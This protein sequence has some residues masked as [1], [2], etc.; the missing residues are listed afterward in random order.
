MFSNPHLTG[1]LSTRHRKALNLSQRTLAIPYLNFCKALQQ[2]FWFNCLPG[3][4]I[5]SQL[6]A[7][8]ATTAIKRR[9]RVVNKSLSQCATSSNLCNKSTKA[10][11]AIHHQTVITS[12]AICKLLRKNSLVF[13]TNTVFAW[14]RGSKGPNMSKSRRWVSNIQYKILSTGSLKR[15]QSMVIVNYTCSCKKSSTPTHDHIT[16]VRCCWNSP[17]NTIHSL[18]AHLANQLIISTC[19][20]STHPPTT[21]YVNSLSFLSLSLC[22]HPTINPLSERCSI[23]LSEP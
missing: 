8:G 9:T 11:I 5:R 18:A 14:I 13:V 2:Q 10:K 17:T 12:C 6:S 3:K 23:L 15:S 4:C 20:I 7:S 21:K 16:I 19:T 1:I 22:A